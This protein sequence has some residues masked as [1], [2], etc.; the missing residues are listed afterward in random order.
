MPGTDQT[1]LLWN[2]STQ[3]P[4]AVPLDQVQGRLASGTHSL[5]SESKVEQ[6][7]APG[8][9]AKFD[10]GEAAYREKALDAQQA[11]TT[12]AERSAE[13]AKDQHKAQFAGAS[14]AVEAFQQS[15][16]KA[17]T[18]GIFDPTK[19][20]ERRMQLEEHPIADKAGELTAIAVTLLPTG[21]ESAGIG[22]AELGGKAIKAT[23]LGAAVKIQEAAT[24]ALRAKRIAA[25]GKASVLRA[26]LEEAAGGFAGGAV[27]ATGHQVGNALQGRP[28]SGDA[29][30]DDIGLSTVLSGGLGVVGGAFGRQAAKIKNARSEI[31]SA[32]EL[33]KVIPEASASFKEGVASWKG[34]HVEASRRLKALNAFDRQG[35][36]D[37]EQTGSEW[38][39]DRRLAA[40]EASK[41]EAKVLK[42]AGVQSIE[43]A[44]SRM[45]SLLSVGKAKDIEKLATA[46][47]EWGDAVEHFDDVMR[48]LDSDAQHLLDLNALDDLDGTMP[49]HEHTYGVLGE[50]IQKGADDASLLKYAK[51]QGLELPIQDLKAEVTGAASP[52]GRA[53]GKPKS[54]FA[55]Q[56]EAQPNK[57]VEIPRGPTRNM[58][59]EV[60]GEAPAELP[61]ISELTVEPP[62]VKPR[63]KVAFK[64][65][66][67][68]NE[69]R[70]G[71]PFTPQSALA[72]KL[73]DIGRRIIENTGG[74]LGTEEA[75]L[76]ASKLGINTQKVAEAGHLPQAMVDV[77][78]LK[79]LAEAAADET[80][81]I[82]QAVRSRKPGVL[83][84]AIR[85]GAISKGR[86]AARAVGGPFAGG[87]VGSIMAS[88]THSVV[89]AAGVLAAVGGRFRD[90]AVT[91]IAKAL[92]PVGRRAITTAIVSPMKVSYDGSTP[93]SDYKKKA[94][95]LR[96]LAGST[97][98][99]KPIV[100]N[101]TADIRMIDPAAAAAA[102]EAVM[103]RLKN[104]AAMLPTDTYRGPLLPPGP[105]SHE[106][107]DDFHAYEA[108][109]ADKE[110]VFQYIKAGSMPAAVVSAMREQHPD[111]LNEV[112]Q[113]VFEHPDEVAK[114]PHDS[115]MALSA[116]IGI[117]LV[118]EADPLYIQRQQEAYQKAKEKAAQQKMSQ[119]GAN[120]IRGGMPAPLPMT[121]AQQFAVLPSIR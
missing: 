75:R 45:E 18:L 73:N 94:A 9:T 113:W 38:L 72:N 106:A 95:Q 52:R 93:T 97:E 23:P 98:A 53:A 46:F 90:A 114:S 81:G 79:R 51:E 37:A 89:G 112:K 16:V 83:T 80:T 27:M 65:H 64:A 50:M 109:T 103:R 111:F 12:A 55:E 61:P 100:D 31:I 102:G 86:Q 59:P 66:Q 44:A 101:A 32:A 107:L 36:L 21:G 54:E 63:G 60:P 25:G 56:I 49:S 76:L 42:L 7:V 34:A 117:P 10:P 22:L 8:V 82:G 69:T 110:L 92:S 28:V 3:L 2:N 119:Q 13:A 43:N 26:G 48:P 74:R 116:L 96:Q 4:E 118:P 85:S 78:S 24:Q 41:A 87:F 47:G 91:G 108:I 30:V 121:P 17:M 20:D 29:I 5:Y 6:T 84:N 11:L 70:Y 115:L 67:I 120:A 57:T 33:D 71:L 15:Y 14:D 40:K 104:L 68:L 58:R 1:S 105:P 77:W 39:S 88:A 99:L 62:A 35:M 19:T